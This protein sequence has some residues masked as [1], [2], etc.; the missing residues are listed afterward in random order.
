LFLLDVGKLLVGSGESES[1]LRQMI[2]VET[3]SPAFYGLMK[4]IKLFTN[5]E[6]RGDSGTSNRV[7]ATF[8]S[9]RKTKP[10]LLFQLQIILTYYH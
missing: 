5:T 6:S 4:L 9:Y 10:V 2:N 3:I 8:I 7:L 1:R